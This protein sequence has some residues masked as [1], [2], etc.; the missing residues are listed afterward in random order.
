M[1]KKELDRRKRHG[2][3]RKKMQGTA[4]KPR[5]YVYRSL[6]NLFMVGMD[7]T[8]DKVLVSASTLDKEI[9]SKAPRGGNIQSAGY[10]G[11]LSA[12]KIKEKG[13]TR[14]IFDRSGYLYHGRIKAF[15]EAMRKG[16]VEF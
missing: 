16:G 9:K 5:V 2:R 10:L 6:N 14:I 15:A 4:E 11:E 12:K 7:D 13:I 3:I 1:K 8:A